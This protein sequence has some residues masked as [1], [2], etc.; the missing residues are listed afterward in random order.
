MLQTYNAHVRDEHF[1]T[2]NLKSVFHSNTDTTDGITLTNNTRTDLAGI[3]D[4]ASDPAVALDTDAKRSAMHTELEHK[5]KDHPTL[6]EDIYLNMA[7]RPL[8]QKLF[9]AI[10]N[11]MHRDGRW[12]KMPESP[13]NEHQVEAQF[14][15]I[16]DQMNDHVKKSQLDPDGLLTCAQFIDTHAKHIVTRDGRYLE[17]DI[18]VRGK[19][20]SFPTLPESS[21][22]TW[23]QC[24]AVGE[25]KLQRGSRGMG[26]RPDKSRKRKKEDRSPEKG[27]KKDKEN[28][29]QLATYVQQVFMAQENRRFVPAF[30]LDQ[31][32]FQFF[33]FDRSGAAVGRWI[34]YHLEPLPFCALILALLIFDDPA[35]GFDPSIGFEKDFQWIL[36]GRGTVS[37]SDPMPRMR[38]FVEKT[39]FHSVRLVGKG[40]VYWLAHNDSKNDT[41]FVLVDSWTPGGYDGQKWFLDVTEKIDGVASVIHIQNVH[42]NGQLDSISHN[43]PGGAYG[44]NLVHTRMV[45][46]VSR[47]VKLL[48]K[49]SSTLELLVAVRDVVLGAFCLI[50]NGLRPTCSYQGSELCIFQPEI[51]H[52]ALRPT[53]FYS[54]QRRSKANA[55]SS[56]T[57][58]SE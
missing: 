37:H 31:S 53:I 14:L 15:T 3:T 25:V 35:V 49:F 52:G 12:I 26:T 57:R 44:V 1:T 7:R 47:N 20:P 30:L 13:L 28:R 51:L 8:V 2:T 16:V 54:N 19:G 6:L 40:E 27:L 22:P 11:K 48:E 24:R 21:T 41:P 4:S 10:D 34:D 43:R 33:I 42:V 9:D 55:A 50:Y 18:F 32:C 45:L 5:W 38:Y 56:S 39:I 23:A 58:I 17:P 46:L 29:S 36:T